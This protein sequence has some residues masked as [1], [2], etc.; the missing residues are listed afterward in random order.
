M[1]RSPP[2]Q[3]ADQQRWLPSQREQRPLAAIVAVA[4]IGLTWHHW[5]AGDVDFEHVQPLV[6]NDRIDANQAGWPELM[7]LPGIGETLAR[8]IVAERRSRGRF[9]QLEDLLHVP[10]IGKA[11]LDRIRPFLLEPSGN[12][13]A[14]KKR[15]P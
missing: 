6:L 8:R 7:L 14:H 9:E 4:L 10:G 2:Q 15:A 3:H 13:R 5:R 1:R 12:R 11:T